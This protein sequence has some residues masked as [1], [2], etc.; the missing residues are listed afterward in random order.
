[1]S[2]KLPSVAPVEEAEEAED[3][4]E[5]VAAE[6]VTTLDVA[7]VGMVVEVDTNKE[8]EADTVRDAKAV[9]EDMAEAKVNITPEEED[10]P[11]VAVEEEVTTNSN[12]VEEV[13]VGKRSLGPPT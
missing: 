12:R 4:V 8:V 7:E 6:E 1:V 5:A 10:N 9:E 11:M 13:D 3:M 2:T